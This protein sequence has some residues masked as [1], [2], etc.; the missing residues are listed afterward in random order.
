MTYTRVILHS[1]GLGDAFPSCAAL[2]TYNQPEATLA[3]NAWIN[4]RSGFTVDIEVCGVVNVVVAFSSSA[5]ATWGYQGAIAGHVAHRTGSAAGGP[6]SSD[7][8]WN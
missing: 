5:W 1:D 8:T 7:P 6:V 3:A 2:G 4:G